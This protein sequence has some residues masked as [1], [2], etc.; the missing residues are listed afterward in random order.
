MGQ[1]YSFNFN[2]LFFILNSSFS[3]ACTI[4][5]FTHVNYVSHF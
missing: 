1:L 4:K 5:S 3:G 2:F